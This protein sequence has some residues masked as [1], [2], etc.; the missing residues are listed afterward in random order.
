MR[1]C[2]DGAEA[3]G[4]CRVSRFW[5]G[6]GRGLYTLRPVKPSK[7]TCGIV[8]VR[9][10]RRERLRD[11]NAARHVS[12]PVLGCADVVANSRARQL[13][14]LIPRF[15]VVDGLRVVC[16]AEADL[17][18][19]AVIGAGPAG[20]TAALYLARFRRC[21]AVLDAG[22]SRAALIPV[23]HNFPGF[24]DGV[25]GTALLRILE[26]QIAR[27]GVSVV[28]AEVRQLQ[29]ADS[30]FKLQTREDSLR[31]RTVLLA[32]GCVDQAPE[33]PCT[34]DAVRGGYLRYCP[35]CDGFEVIDRDVAVLGNSDHAAQEA[36][37]VR[38]FTS[39]VTLLTGGGEPAM[40]DAVR[41]KL[42]ACGIVVVTDTIESGHVESDRFVCVFANGA[43]KGFNSLYLA[44]GTTMRSGLALALGAQCTPKGELV[45]DA[46]MQTSV[47]GL[48][49]AGD[50]VKALSQMTVAAGEAAI[51]ATAIHNLLR[52]QGDAA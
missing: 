18:D 16:M 47:P 28:S 34:A 31:A 41:D 7:F 19:C 5:G 29:R 4:I 22:A 27:Y 1:H 49:A 40:A 9:K 15:P 37:F 36:L 2:D 50:V 24:P 26:E 14:N 45:V 42:H 10:A 6:N 52:E 21:I 3:G 33:W 11:V 13:A 39:Q 20:L 8:T 35:I 48:Y 43:R 32:T 23:S 38:H 30:H 25:A 46:R 44:L 17:F 51:A 12:S